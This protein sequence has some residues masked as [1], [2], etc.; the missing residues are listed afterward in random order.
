LGEVPVT[1]LAFQIFLIEGDGCGEFLLIGMVADDARINRQKDE[2]GAEQEGEDKLRAGDGFLDF[3][4]NDVFK[5]VPPLELH[6]PN[7]IHIFHIFFNI[8]MAA[9]R[10]IHPLFIRKFSRKVKK[11]RTNLFYGFQILIM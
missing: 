1:W 2:D 6:R 9:V 4:L 7:I 11:E 8:A 3:F 5:H 10:S